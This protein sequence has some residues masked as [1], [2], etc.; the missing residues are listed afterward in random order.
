MLEELQK[1]LQTLELHRAMLFEKRRPID[2]ELS[3]NYEKLT[4]AREQLAEARVAEM[5]EEN[6]APSPGNW[7]SEKEL[8]LILMGE[9]NSMTLYRHSE[10]LLQNR[11]N[12]AFSRYGYCPE[13]EQASFRIA[14]KKG[15]SARTRLVQDA[16]VYML[17]H[18]KWRTKDRYDRELSHHQIRF[19]IFEHN[20]C[21]G[22]R[23]FD[24]VYTTENKWYIEERWSKKEYLVLAEALEYIQENLWYERDEG[25]SSSDYDDDDY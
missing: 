8:E 6:F 19:H 14:L 17:P 11:F 5:K 3:S 9:T 12:L 16:I 24:L 23:S 7:F 22:G 1:N 25:T 21:E 20:L 15:D 10:R 4:K 18:L 2:E 13:T